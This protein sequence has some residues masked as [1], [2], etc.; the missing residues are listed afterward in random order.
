VILEISDAWRSSSSEWHGAAKER[1]AACR[2]ALESAVA[3]AAETLE[4]RY[5]RFFKT[6]ACSFSAGGG[7]AHYQPVSEEHRRELAQS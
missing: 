1:G 7:E 4:E 3:P 2:G 5:E 6:A